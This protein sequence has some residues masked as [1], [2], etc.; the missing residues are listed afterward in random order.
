MLRCRFASGVDLMR[1]AIDEL[2]ICG[3]PGWVRVDG[4]SVRRVWWYRCSFEEM[5]HADGQKLYLFCLLI[6][7]EH[8]LVRTEFLRIHRLVFCWNRL[9]RLQ[10]GY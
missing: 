8:M 9:R 3:A 6:V 10:K 4:G 5:D 1:D 2:A 7:V